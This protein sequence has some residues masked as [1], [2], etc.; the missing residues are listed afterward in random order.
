MPTIPQRKGRERRSTALTRS[1]ARLAGLCAAAAAPHAAWAQTTASFQVSATIE[2]G[3]SVDGI[4]TGGDAGT[5]G[6]LDFGR[7]SSFSTATHTASLSGSQ[8]FTL[9]CTPGV[10]L[11]MT[12][13][14][15]ENAAGGVRNLQLGSDTASRLQYRLYSD[16]G[17][18]DEIGINASTGIAVTTA[19]MNDVRLPVHARLTLPGG[20]P[21]GT[22]A[23]TLLVVLEW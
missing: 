20:R 10:D 23:D 13:D 17:F 5:M 9:R 1:R 6:V 3:C 19:N 2:A 7:D 15:G 16:A 22:Y 21:A 4:G 11:S 12:I 8:T 14:G 18:G